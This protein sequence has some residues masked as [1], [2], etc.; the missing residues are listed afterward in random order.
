MRVSHSGPLGDSR[1]A[2]PA[3][4]RTGMPRTQAASRVGL[5]RIWVPSG[6]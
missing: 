3:S 6:R 1:A 5:T 4:P 2:A